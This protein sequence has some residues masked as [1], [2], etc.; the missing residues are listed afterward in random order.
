VLSSGSIRSVQAVVAL[1]DRGS[2][3]SDAAKAASGQL[4]A[5]SVPQLPPQQQAVEAVEASGASLPLPQRRDQG[6]V[7]VS[8]LSVPQS[9]ADSGDRSLRQHFT[10]KG[11]PAPSPFEQA[12]GGSA[13][14]DSPQI[15]ANGSTK[16]RIGST[17]EPLDLEQQGKSGASGSGQGGPI[18]WDELAEPLPLVQTA[19]AAQFYTVLVVDAPVEEFTYR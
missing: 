10:A 7:E 1:E 17:E 13:F 19:D 4:G 5:P 18:E 16:K 8:S 14:L 9:L 11:V 12:S 6:L 2:T 15:S 3:T